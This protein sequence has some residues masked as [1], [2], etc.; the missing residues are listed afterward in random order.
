MAG[1]VIV[2]LVVANGDVPSRGAKPPAS[3]SI[4]LVPTGE[5][6]IDGEDTLLAARDLRPG[7]P[8][9]GGESTKLANLTRKPVLVQ[10][11]LVSSGRDLDRLV[12]AKVAIGK[13]TIA[14]GT[15]EQLRSWSKRM[16]LLPV[17][18]KQRVRVGAWLVGGEDLRYEGLA[19]SRTAATAGANGSALA[20]ARARKLLLSLIVL[21]LAGLLAGVGTYSAFSQ[22]TTNGGDS[23]AAGTVSI[24][25]NDAATAMLSL[26]G[27]KPGDST[28]GCIRVT[29]SGSLDAGVRLY[30]S[31]SGALA[32]YLT[33][34]VTRGTDA[35]P[36]FPSCAGFSADGTDYIG[37]GAGVVYD[38]LLSGYPASYAAG[39]VDP[40]AGSPE[41]WTTAEVHSYRFRATLANDPSAQ[42]QSGTA[43]FTWEARNL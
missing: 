37:A 9:F 15:L 41:T 20:V 24:S 10:L 11:R 19:A 28:T 31:V 35:A 26:S 43:S 23:F 40:H 34:T 25:D 6:G 7:R 3:L 42:G 16:Y 33:L 30:G 38:G 4:G 18:G 2:C 12:Q 29:Y 22:S 32:P 8:V 5:L 14:S 17:H 21:G 1:I 36:S 39:I 13:R 27:A